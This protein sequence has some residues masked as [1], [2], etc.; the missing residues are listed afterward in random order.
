MIRRHLPLLTLGAAL[1]AIA[2]CARHWYRVRE[3]GSVPV[4]TRVTVFTEPAGADVAAAG[5]FKG[6]S[7]IAIPFRYRY[8][9]VVY[10]RERSYVFTRDQEE[11]VLPEYFN[12][13]FVIEVAKPGYVP[14]THTITLRG[15]KEK[16]VHIPLV[17][18]ER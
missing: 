7:P 1:L 18:I 15:E 11:K 14:A 2:A 9:R 3:E 13:T 10:A 5:A 6:A 4:V 17:P 16:E 12:N 8:R